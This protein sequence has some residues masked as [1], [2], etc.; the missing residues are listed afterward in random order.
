MDWNK[1]RRRILY[2]GLLGV[3]VAV[4]L[5]KNIFLRLGVLR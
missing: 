2:L 1:Y 4:G 3:I 5:A